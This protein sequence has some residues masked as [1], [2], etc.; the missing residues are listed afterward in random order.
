MGGNQA[1]ARRRNRHFD[2][3]PATQVPVTAPAPPAQLPGGDQGPTAAPPVAVPT[4]PNKPLP[5]PQ[6]NVPGLPKIGTGGTPQDGGTGG[7][8]QRTNQA[9]LDYLMGK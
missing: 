6:V 1:A 8:D 9:L 7:S 5:L 2:G 3:D 4:T